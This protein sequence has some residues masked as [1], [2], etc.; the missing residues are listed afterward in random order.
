MLFLSPPGPEAALG[1]L[2]EQ[3]QERVRAILAAIGLACDPSRPP[4]ALIQALAEP[5]EDWAVGAL[6]LAGLER[7]AELAYLS[8][9]LRLG[10]A[11][12]PQ[13][14]DG[15]VLPQQGGSWPGGITVRRVADARAEDAA[16]H[17]GLERSYEDTL[18]CPELAGMRSVR[19]IV[20]SHRAVGDFDPALWWVVE[21][22]G[23]PEGCVLVNRCPDQGCCELVYIGLSP[24]LR[25]LGLGGA[26]LEAAIASSASLERELRCAVD[27]RND[28]A[29]RMYTRLGFV[30][31]GRRVAM[32]ARPRDVVGPSVSG[33][34][35]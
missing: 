16:L 24:R 17:R 10:E 11:R 4:V 1:G 13:G 25:G 7:I 30:D 20:A 19:D 32:V 34:P 2:R 29:R 35:G 21:Q 26:L 15:L 9:Q 6:E 3:L 5:S 8:R 28:P 14:T 31:R 27:Q 18:D 23:E 33:A 12:S 22:G